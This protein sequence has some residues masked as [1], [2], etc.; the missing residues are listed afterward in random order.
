MIEQ[1]SIEFLEA[2][3]EAINS[4]QNWSRILFRYA[5]NRLPITFEYRDRLPV[6]NYGYFFMSRHYHVIVLE[7]DL[8]KC[9][10]CRYGYSGHRF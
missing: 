2:S 3:Y 8:T 1:A 4:R 6:T 5:R 10:A 9:S 7:G